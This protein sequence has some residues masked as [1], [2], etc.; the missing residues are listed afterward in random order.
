[1]RHRHDFELNPRG[2]PPRGVTG[3]QP[4][5]H[6]GAATTTGTHSREETQAVGQAEPRARSGPGNDRAFG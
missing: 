4:G 6:A 3:R 2:E 1:M 5:N